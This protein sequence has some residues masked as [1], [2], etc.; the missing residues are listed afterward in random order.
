VVV[1]RH[2][3]KTTGGPALYRGGGSIGIIG[4]ARIALLVGRDPADEA[5]NVLAAIKTNI[6]PKPS[7]SHTGCHRTVMAPSG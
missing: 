2:L 6:G 1:I 5:R 3:N 4:A 7:A